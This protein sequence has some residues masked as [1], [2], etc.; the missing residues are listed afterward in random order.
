MTTEL[1]RRV[2]IV[3]H[4][5]VELEGLV[6]W[7]AMPYG[8]NLPI[9]ATSLPDGTVLETGLRQ[10]AL[11]RAVVGRKEWVSGTWVQCSCCGQMYVRSE[12]LEPP[13]PIAT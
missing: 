8:E 3:S 9:F 6:K 12:L 13:S 2:T 4:Y 11:Y 5:V 7:L 1:E 10:R